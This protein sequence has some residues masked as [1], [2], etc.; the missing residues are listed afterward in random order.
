MERQVKARLAELAFK[1]QL[2]AAEGRQ[3]DE[4]LQATVRGSRDRMALIERHFDA[5]QTSLEPS[6]QAKF[7]LWGMDQDEAFYTGSGLWTSLM[8]KELGLSA[9]Q[10]QHILAR[11]PVIRQERQNLLLAERMMTQLRQHVRTSHESLNRECDAL[12]S[13]MTPGQLA[14]YFVWVEQ[15]TWCMSMLDGKK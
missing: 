14:R 2:T 6:L 3:L 7:A 13:I 5:V 11:R 9:E 8:F 4:I 1:Q 12:L 10:A 15:N